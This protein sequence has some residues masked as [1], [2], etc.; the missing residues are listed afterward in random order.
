MFLEPLLFP[1]PSSA[2]RRTKLI[3]GKLNHQCIILNIFIIIIT[4]II[5]GNNNI[6]IN[7][8]VRWG[9]E[10]VTPVFVRSLST[11]SNWIGVHNQKLDWCP[12]PETGL[13]S[14]LVFPGSIPVLH[15]NLWF[16]KHLKPTSGSAVLTT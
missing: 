6:I 11:T 5:I 10:C 14:R 2:W 4:F 9:G 15:T 3:S 12:Q 1:S 8:F 13:V 7:S 16:Q